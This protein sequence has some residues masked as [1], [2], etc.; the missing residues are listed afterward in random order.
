MPVSEKIMYSCLFDG[1][2]VG[3]IQVIDPVTSLIKET[4]ESVF[5]FPAIHFLTEGDKKERAMKIELKLSDALNE[6]DVKLDAAVARAVRA[7]Q[8]RDRLK[9]TLILITAYDRKMDD[10]VLLPEEVRKMA[11]AALS[12]EADR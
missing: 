9:E 4:P 6:A 10:Y 3:L 8:E 7:E 12:V 5:M 2:A 1:T 11:R